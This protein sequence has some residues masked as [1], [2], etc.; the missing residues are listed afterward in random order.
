VDGGSG[1]NIISKRLYDT[2]DLPKIE[3]DPFSMKMA[4]QITITPLGLVKNVFVEIVG[5]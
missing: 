2:W 1:I 3:F 4:D 5:I